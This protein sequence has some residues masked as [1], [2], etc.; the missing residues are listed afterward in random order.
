MR[1]RTITLSCCLSQQHFLTEDTLDKLVETSST[2]LKQ[3]AEAYKAASYDVQTIRIA[4]NSFE[5]WLL[6]T[7]AHSD[8]PLANASVAHLDASV[9]KK[10]DIL[11]QLLLKYNISFCSLGACRKSENLRY[12]PHILNQSYPG[13]AC[14]YGAGIQ[15]TM[16][17]FLR[18]AETCVELSKLCG[19]NGN[20]GY[21]VASNCPD[22]IPFFPASSAPSSSSIS[23][24]KETYSISVGLE[25][26]DLLFLGTKGASSYSEATENLK[27]VFYQAMFPIHKIMKHALNSIAED[28]FEVNYLGLDTS[29]APGLELPESVGF[30]IE[31]F[32]PSPLLSGIEPENA[33][34]FG[35]Y[36]TLPIIGAITAALKSINDCATNED[37]KILTT[38]YNGLMLP[39]MEDI[40]LAQRAREKKLTIRDFMLFCTSCGVG[41]D[42][43]PISHDVSVKKLAGL[44]LE[45]NAIAHR[46][47]KSL[48][49]RLLPMNELKAGDSTNSI[50]PYLVDT[51]VFDL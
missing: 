16:D 5:E 25:A 28:N 35:D 6:P 7:Q 36:G 14:S 8:V 19:D 39:V 48:S 9:Q 23:S 42:T 30:G 10:L 3:I 21:C 33:F 27:S 41:I 26:G 15:S 40:I 45:M 49:C 17:D 32:G 50:S 2:V 44:Y 20:F 37:G 34:Q 13:F 22:G 38:G 4:F 43:V 29:I 18:A 46:L 24:G 1:I 31:Q 11:Q 51:T 47:G 12:I